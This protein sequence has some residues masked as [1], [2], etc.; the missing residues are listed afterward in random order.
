LA[1]AIPRKWGRPESIMPICRF[2][3]ERQYQ[4]MES[5]APN[6]PNEGEAMVA[7]S[8][9]TERTR[10]HSFYVG[11]AAAFVLI[12]FVGFT[13]TYW[14]K[15]TAGKFH[16]APIMHIH[17]GMFFFWTLFFFAQTALVAT[18]RT[19]DH[20]NWGWPASRSLPPWP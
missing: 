14:T 4:T 6:W 2:L 10:S 3:L 20:R 19:P 5:C 9:A 15:L 13:P 1:R 18:G 11:M 17:G 7:V 8:L 16:G 12:A